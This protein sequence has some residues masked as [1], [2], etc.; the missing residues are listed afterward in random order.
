MIVRIIVLLMAMMS[1]LSQAQTIN[2]SYAFAVIGEPK[3]AINFDHYDYVNPAAP[4]GGNLTLAANGTF[5]NFNRYALRGV[6]AERTDALYDT[7]FTTSDDEPG[8]YYPLVAE[9]ARYAD[10]FA[11]M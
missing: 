9:Q 10:D 5:D 1:G 2:E 8:S 11:W 4:K 7:L 6:A 3:Y